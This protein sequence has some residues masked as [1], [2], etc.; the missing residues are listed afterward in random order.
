MSDLKAWVWPIVV[1]LLVLQATL[2][3]FSIH[4]ES[5]TFDEADHMYAG[6]RMWT[7]ADYGLNPEHPPLVKLL[8]ALPILGEKLQMPPLLGIYFKMEANMNGG[9]WIAQNDDLSHHLVFRMRLAT[10]LLALALS[11]LIFLATRQWFG[12]TAALIALCFAVF[13]PNILAHSGLVTTDIGCALFF[14][15]AVYAFNRYVE[16]PGWA[17]LVIA[18]I[19]AG[20]LLATKHSGILVAPILPLLAAY[21]IAI[22]PRGMRPRLALRLCGACAAIAAISI[23]VLWSFYGFRFAARP[24]GLQLVPTLEQYASTMKPFERSLILGIA[25]L[26]LLPESYLMGI[27]DIRVFSSSFNTF[28]LG[29][30]YPH[31]LWWYFPFIL[32]IKSTLA[33]LAALALTAFAIVA[34]KLSLSRALGYHLIAGAVFLAV[35]MQNG[36]NI[37]VRHILPIYALGAVLAGA[38]LATLAPRSRAW[39]WA[40]GILLAAHIA[41]SL[42]VY[43]NSIAYANE[44]WGGA[45]YTHLNLTDSNVD[46]GQQLVQVRAWE[47]RHPGEDCWLGYFATGIVS[48]GTYGVRCHLLPSGLNVFARIPVKESAPAVIHGA[49]LLS[50]SEAAGSIWD[51]KTINPYQR[52]Q[53][54]RPDEIIDDGVLVFHGDIPMHEAAAASRAV[55]VWYLLGQ[56]QTQ[57]A[58]ALAEEAVQIAPNYIYALWALGDA[59]A[60]SGHKEDARTAYEKALQ[61]TTS[62]EPERQR[63]FS[64]PIQEALSKL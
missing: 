57:P 50:A 26:H 25:H 19:A 35:A 14:L 38:G 9:Q 11:L 48:P 58:L 56:K 3:L 29:T 13:D 16:R 7:A 15:A 45:R 34:K 12:E 36:L 27:T 20:L 47:D 60:A 5:L 24:V 52:F 30:W 53:D 37:G 21:E 64:Q 39:T 40:C 43:P 61:A 18:G 42:S 46:W 32:I 63:D 44:A 59:A 10:V 8:A 6:Y 17:R 55:Q 4:R 51:S 41:S 54:V 62:I 31:G 1:G 33:L 49:V 2:I 28:A 23:L 22:A